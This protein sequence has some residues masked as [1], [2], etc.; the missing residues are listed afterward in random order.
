MLKVYSSILKLVKKNA[1][2]NKSTE[3]VSRNRHFASDDL[4]NHNHL[5]KFYI[6]SPRFTP[7][8]SDSSSRLDYVRVISTP[9]II[10]II[11]IHIQ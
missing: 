6:H 4:Q 7:R 3:L 1:T 11:I 8:A 2:Y 9:I 5:H 10:I